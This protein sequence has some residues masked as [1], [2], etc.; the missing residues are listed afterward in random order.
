[1]SH[2]A[3]DIA[4]PT[5]GNGASSPPRELVRGLRLGSTARA[6]RSMYWTLSTG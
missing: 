2:A 6:I 4:S 3:F 5:V 1:M